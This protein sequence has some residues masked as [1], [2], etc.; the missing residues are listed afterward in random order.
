MISASSPV[1]SS[2]PWIGEYVTLT[3]AL[4]GIGVAVATRGAGL[5]K[6]RDAASDPYRTAAA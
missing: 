5:V 4:F 6:P 3:L 2:V 1:A